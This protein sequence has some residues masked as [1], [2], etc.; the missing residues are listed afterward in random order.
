M[1]P[2]A[3]KP[4]NP[5]PPGEPMIVHKGRSTG[6]SVLMVGA[7]FGK[8]ETLR[9][10][11]AALLAADHRLFV[12]PQNPPA[13]VLEALRAE[14]AREAEHWIF[15]DELKTPAEIRALLGRE[16]VIVAHEA[17]PMITAESILAAKEKLMQEP[18][19]FQKIVAER[20]P[21][22]AD[23]NATEPWPEPSD[24][25]AKRPRGFAKAKGWKAKQRA[26]RKAQR[27]ARQ[28]ARG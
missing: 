15:R 8:S 11:V 10:Q 16:V 17:N 1:N 27:R 21:I 9:Q 18:P 2:E 24:K 23:T 12:V 20:I 26:K 25:P 3:W 5:E 7:N 19:A 22:S 6:K 13:E 4:I 14:R 28:R